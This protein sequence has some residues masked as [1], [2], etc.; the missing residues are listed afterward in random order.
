MRLQLIL[1][2]SFVFLTSFVL[3]SGKGH[4]LMTDHRRK[5]PKFKFAS[6]KSSL[7]S[8]LVDSPFLFVVFTHA[9]A[10]GQTKAWT[11][12]QKGLCGSL[13]K[14]LLFKV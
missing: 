3:P 4:F 9:G 11:G 10:S 14:V 13:V 12:R 5:D 6:R 7:V 2:N 1:L 8:A